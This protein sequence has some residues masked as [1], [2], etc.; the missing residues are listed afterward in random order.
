MI[1]AASNF[2]HLIATKKR[3]EHRL[4]VDGVYAWTRH[5]SYVAFTYWAL[6]TQVVLGN[7]FS[8]VGFAIVLRAYFRHRIIG[9]S[10]GV[11][12]GDGDECQPRC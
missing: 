1:T 5:P 11:S 2:T 9:A 3:A 6:G 7:T 12:P 10:T 4:V 8:F